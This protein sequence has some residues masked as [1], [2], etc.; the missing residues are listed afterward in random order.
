MKFND[1]E[2]ETATNE[3]LLKMELGHIEVQLTGLNLSQRL[4]SLEG[5]EVIAEYK[6]PGNFDTVVESLYDYATA[7]KDTGVNEKNR[8][9]IIARKKDLLHQREIADSDDKHEAAKL[10]TILE[11]IKTH[12]PDHII[13]TAMIQNATYSSDDVKLRQDA[14]H[15]AKLC[16]CYTN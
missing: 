9:E 3:E 8:R 1:I 10:K 4:C 15:N 13:E 12:D 7:L 2:L 14:L 11:A 5:R 6:F 16:L